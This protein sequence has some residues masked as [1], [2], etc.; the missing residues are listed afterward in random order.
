MK[1]KLHGFGADAITVTWSK[2]RCIHA[3]ECVAGL[4]RVFQP[5]E[6]PWIKLDAAAAG[7]I[8]G[9]VRRSAKSPA[10]KISNLSFSLG[11]SSIG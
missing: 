5:G 1:D 9:I 2:R 7:T 3:A 11:V 8:A 10:V 4:P 6:R